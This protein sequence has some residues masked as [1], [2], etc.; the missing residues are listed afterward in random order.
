MGDAGPDKGQHHVF[1]AREASMMIA[2]QISAIHRAGSCPEASRCLFSVRSRA[3]VPSHCAGP[4]GGDAPL[5][6]MVPSLA[7]QPGQPAPARGK[8][9]SRHGTFGRKCRQAGVSRAVAVQAGRLPS[10]G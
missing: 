5:C 6:G 1:K 10:A 7:R 9:L 3:K 8:R 4:Y 2:R